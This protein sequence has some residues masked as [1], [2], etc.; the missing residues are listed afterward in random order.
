MSMI[1]LAVFA[2]KHSTPF[3]GLAALL[4]CVGAALIIQAGEAGPTLIGKLLS[5][6]PFVFIGLISYSL[7]LWHWPVILFQRSDSMLSTI[8]PA[9]TRMTLIVLSIAF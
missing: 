2:Y 8:S 7:Y 9:S 4:P 6:R 3:P 1:L 5:W